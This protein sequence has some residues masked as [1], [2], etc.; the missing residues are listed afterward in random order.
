MQKLLKKHITKECNPQINKH[1]NDE[2]SKL[3]FVFF[4]K[5]FI[6]RFKRIGQTVKNI[7]YKIS[8]E[9]FKIKMRKEK[10]AFL[11]LLNLHIY[12]N[13]HRYL[14]G[15]ILCLS[16]IFKKWVISSQE[17]FRFRM[18]IKRLKH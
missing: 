5:A 8:L 6:K 17:L 14:K 16:N 15:F 9:N 4:L 3:K 18:A 10:H 1:K 13:H 11:L 2:S 7:L 12:I